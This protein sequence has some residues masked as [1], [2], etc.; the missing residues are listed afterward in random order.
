MRSFANNDISHESN[1]NLELQ[2]HDNLF[3]ITN[4]Q[5]QRLKTFTRIKRKEL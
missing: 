4:M 2:K 5:R 3:G 1:S